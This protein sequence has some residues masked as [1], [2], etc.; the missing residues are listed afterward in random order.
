MFTVKLVHLT[1]TFS[2][3]C[4]RLTRAWKPAANRVARAVATSHSCSI[5]HCMLSHGPSSPS[6]FFQVPQRHF[7]VTVASGTSF[8]LSSSMS[9]NHSPPTPPARKLKLA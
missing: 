2:G 7:S 8:V 9:P 5:I 4:E 3:V 1:S 6:G